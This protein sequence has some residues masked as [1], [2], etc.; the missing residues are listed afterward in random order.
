[1]VHSKLITRNNFFALLLVCFAGNLFA[2]NP[3]LIPPVLTGTTFNLNVQSGTTQLFPG[4]PTPTYG[5]NGSFLAPTIVVNKGD[6]VTLNVINNL[7]VAT[8]M[9]WHGLHV[10]PENDGGPHQSIA[11]G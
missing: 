8:T 6:Y 9:H 1:M 10:A 4:N 5:I 3:L 2:Q 11:A 7:N